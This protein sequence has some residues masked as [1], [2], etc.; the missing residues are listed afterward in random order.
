MITILKLTE[1]SLTFDVSKKMYSRGLSW[2]NFD[3]YD[4]YMITFEDG[5]WLFTRS[6][7]WFQIRFKYRW[8]PKGGRMVFVTKARIDEIYEHWDK[9]EKLCKVCSLA[10]ETMTTSERKE[11]HHNYQQEKDEG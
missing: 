7:K 4:F 8:A 5:T 1:D 9:K 3:L 10:L 6:I 11:L 2:S